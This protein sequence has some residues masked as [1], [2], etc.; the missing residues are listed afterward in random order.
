MTDNQEVIA[1][2]V[3]AKKRTYAG[4]LGKIES[5]RPS[6]YDAEYRDG[7][8]CYIDSYLGTH[9]FSGKEAI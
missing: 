8:L 7:A 6:S 2:L 9:Q 5:L 1:F 4:G 3:R